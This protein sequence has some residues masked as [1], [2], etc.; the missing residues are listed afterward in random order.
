[1][2][3]DIRK[4]LQT[5][6]SRLKTERDRLERQITAVESVLTVTG[7]PNSGRAKVERET[8]LA[9]RRR[10]RMSAAARRVVS[11]RMKA[12]WAKRRK[13]DSKTKRKTA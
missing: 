12:Y 11:S 9:K 13:M 10:R 2:P 7:H 3:V 5:V 8:K 4:P 6:L 1:M